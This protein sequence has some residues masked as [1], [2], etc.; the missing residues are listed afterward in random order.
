MYI[1]ELIGEAGPR[2]RRP[3]FDLISDVYD[4]LSCK[5][6]GPYASRFLYHMQD[7]RSALGRREIHEQCTFMINYWIDQ[8]STAGITVY[9]PRQTGNAS[10]NPSDVIRFI[11]AYVINRMEDLDIPR[12]ADRPV[13]NL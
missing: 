2:N 10:T 9:R 6:D 13:I 3:N 4:L 5:V 11:D 12:V 7:I 8:L 1:Q